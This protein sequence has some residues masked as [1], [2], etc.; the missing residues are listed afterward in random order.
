[1]NK[2]ISKTIRIYECDNI[3]LKKLNIKQSLFIRNAIKEKIER[4]F[5]IKTNIPF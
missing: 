1:M 4:N 2:L 5:K 3:L